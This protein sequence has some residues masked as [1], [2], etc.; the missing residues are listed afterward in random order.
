MWIRD[1]FGFIR[2]RPSII[3]VQYRFLPAECLSEILRHN[4]ISVKTIG[5][6]EKIGVSCWSTLV[7]EFVSSVFMKSPEKR[8]LLAHEE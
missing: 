5:L 8:K 3:R 7:C 2:C 6:Q 1:G 4:P